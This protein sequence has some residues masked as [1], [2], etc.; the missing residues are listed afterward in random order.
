M[1]RY[2]NRCFARMRYNVYTNYF[3]ICIFNLLCF[4]L[5][6]CISSLFLYKSYFNDLDQKIKKSAT[7]IE[8]NLSEIFSDIQRLSLYAGK[9]IQNTNTDLEKIFHFL[10]GI[11]NAKYQIKESI[12]VFEW[13]NSLNQCILNSEIGPLKDPID[14]SNRSYTEFCRTNPWVVYF[15]SPVYGITTKLW[16]IPGAV[17][18]TDK[19]EKFKG[20]IT[21][22][23]NIYRL[24]EELSKNLPNS[25]RFL[26]LDKNNT[27]IL[28]SYDR[29]CGKNNKS[30]S[31]LKST[32]PSNATKGELENPV[33]IEDTCY[34]YMT[35]PKIYPYKVIIG[36]N[37]HLVESDLITTIIPKIL[38]ILL[39]YFV[40]ITLL[41]Y[42]HRSVT[43]ISKKATK[44]HR[45]YI[46]TIR[47]GLQETIDQISDCAS[48]LLPLESTNNK[49]S[50][51]IKQ[52]YDLTT[53]LRASNFYTSHFETANINMLIQDCI[54]I[55]SQ[56]ALTDRK[57]IEFFPATP[58][59]EFKVNVMSFKR[60]IL[61]LIS[62]SLKS[63]NQRGHLLIT[64]EYDELKE[65]LVISLKDTGFALSFYEIQ[66]LSKRFGEW[67]SNPLI[68]TDIE[69][70]DIIEIIR[71]HKG[72]ITEDTFEKT[73]KK[74][75]L[76]FPLKENTTNNNSSNSAKVLLFKQPKNKEFL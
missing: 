8:E 58:P 30:I 54:F 35:I 59:P 63:I 56:S 74:I 10:N 14:I 61:G 76:L 12:T 3:T 46:E 51:L 19:K 45:E 16:I 53:K 15:G 18:I 17:G 38:Q 34:T 47:Q 50:K 66:K 65:H 64:A 49:R 11:A 67:T 2:I 29:Q 70:P 25:I 55:Y 27:P 1:L 4:S 21:F 13:S 31:S 5:I 57:Q 52:I 75:I 6:A 32:L 60:M 20:M 40:C 33:K 69:I 7:S 36:Y 48:T 62:L 71:R 44:A 73:G 43:R 68:G 72:S 42:F 41:Y 39:Y 22:G 9:G 24:S 37:S 26:L 28:C 23:I